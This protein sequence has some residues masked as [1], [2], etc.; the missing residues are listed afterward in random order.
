LGF[1]E[2]RKAENWMHLF[3]EAEDFVIGSFVCVFEAV[4]AMSKHSAQTFTLDRPHS[5]IITT[6]IRL[7]V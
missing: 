5:A 2:S 3:A 6:E 1:S 7:G 4:Q